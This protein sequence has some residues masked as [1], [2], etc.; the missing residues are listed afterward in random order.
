MGILP[1]KEKVE[2]KCREMSEGRAMRSQRPRDQSLM[3]A[4]KRERMKQKGRGGCDGDTIYRYAI[5]L[6]NRVIPTG[7]FCMGREIAV[8]PSTA[9]TCWLVWV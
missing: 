6:A 7:L 1:E 9:M 8:T 3:A 2:N 5:G 4:I